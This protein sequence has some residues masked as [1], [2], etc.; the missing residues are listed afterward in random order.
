MEPDADDE[1]GDVNH[2]EQNTTRYAGLIIRLPNAP[3]RRG[4]RDGDWIITE[5]EDAR[6]ATEV[7]V[8]RIRAAARATILVTQP[9]EHRVRVHGPY[10]LAAHLWG[11]DAL[12]ILEV[13]SPSCG[14]APTREL[15]QGAW[16]ANIGEHDA[17]IT[18]RPQHSPP[19]GNPTRPTYLLRVP[20]WCKAGLVAAL[21]HPDTPPRA[22]PFL[23][24][25]SR[26]VA[27][28]WVKQEGTT[29][30]RK[31]NL[32]HPNTFAST[33]VWWSPHGATSPTQAPPSPTSGDAGLRVGS[34]NLAG[35]IG[36]SS[37]DTQP[38]KQGPTGGRRTPA[39]IHKLNDLAQ[40]A[41]EREYDILFVNSCGPRRKEIR[42]VGG[43]TQE[44]VC[45]LVHKNTSI[46]DVN[47]EHHDVLAIRIHPRGRRTA[48]TDMDVGV[49]A[50]G[51]ER[52]QPVM[53]VIRRIVAARL[54][55]TR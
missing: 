3:N 44:G 47:S 39:G 48:R 8:A 33:L 6:G 5:I 16:I 34:I 31:Y 1:P 2:G 51:D 21:R 14:E 40:W 49:Y 30:D 42:E 27:D 19:S 45:A 53:N 10:P 52:W 12:G 37:D 50:P 4:T 54:G 13:I 32:I 23:L 28:A 22:D 35:T 25:A 38:D 9:W 55:V 46:H 24:S 26:F 20:P 18:L 41:E 29:L 7:A 15:T 17:Y 36:S 43:T 11:G